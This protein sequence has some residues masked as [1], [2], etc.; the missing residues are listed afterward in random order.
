MPSSYLD[1][2]RR[3]ENQHF[4]QMHEADQ[5]K[6]IHGEIERLE[7][8]AEIMAETAQHEDTIA[9]AEEIQNYTPDLIVE[10]GHL[11][12]RWETEDM[13]GQIDREEHFS[14]QEQARES[15]R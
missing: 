4:S 9:C 1:K 2:P 5:L 8:L 3:S 6:H 14:S 13:Q 12:K 15:Q 11:I 10:V 7:R